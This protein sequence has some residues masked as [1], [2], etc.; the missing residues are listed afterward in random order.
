[1]NVKIFTCKDVCDWSCSV[2]RWYF[3]LLIRRL[4]V[5]I[6]MSYDCFFD[7]YFFFQHNTDIHT[8]M[9]YTCKF[10]LKKIIK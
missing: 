7:N 6:L 2:F 10:V 4:M 9:L 5:Q 1:M 8:Y 3:F